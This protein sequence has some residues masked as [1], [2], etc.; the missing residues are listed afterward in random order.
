[1]KRQTKWKYYKSHPYLWDYLEDET[2]I[3]RAIPFNIIK[4]R[5]NTST[6]IWAYNKDTKKWIKTELLAYTVIHSEYY[7]LKE[8]NE[9]QLFLELL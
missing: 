5:N 4:I 2:H 1:M 7:K 8:L 3:F 6:Y 9:E